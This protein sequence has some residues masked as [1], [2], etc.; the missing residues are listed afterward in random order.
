MKCPNSQDKNPED[1]RFCIRCGHN[2]AFPSDSTTK[3]LSS[4][5]KLEKIQLYSPIANQPKAKENLKK[6]IDTIITTPKR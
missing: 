5:E 3:D 4:D 2:L 1:A 6:T